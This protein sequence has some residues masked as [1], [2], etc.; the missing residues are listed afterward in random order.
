M[1]YELAPVS[2]SLAGDVARGPRTSL[3]RVVEALE[4]P[5]LRPLR[6]YH[7]Q[8]V[9]QAPCPVHD[10]ASPSLAVRWVSGGG[11]GQVL[12]RCHGCNASFEDLAAA[13]SLSPSDFFD[14]APQQS[15]ADRLGVRA[16]RSPQQ[17][18]A[19]QRRGR[20]GPLPRPIARP[21][22]VELQQ[23]EPEHT[24][25][26]VE[27]YPYTDAQGNLVQEVIRERCTSC[28]TSHKSFRQVFVVGDRRVKR[29]P[30]GF[31]AVLYR[32]PQ[33]LAGVAA[34]TTVWLLEGEKDVAAAEALGLLATTN[35]QGGRNFTP[36]LA[37][38][39]RGAD[40]RVVLDRDDTGWDRGV[41]AHRELTALG[42]TVEL[43]LPAPTTA[44][45]DFS[46]HLDAGHT[47]DQLVPVH[48]EEVAA[49]AALGLV[50]SKAAGVEQT[51]AETQ[52]QLSWPGSPAAPR[53]RRRC[54]SR[55]AGRRRPKSGTRRSTA[56]WTPSGP[57]P[58]TPG[59][60]GPRRP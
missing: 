22:S 45:S 2:E 50:R 16:G 53:G 43:L 25:V 33:V 42:A 60:C 11:R 57:T 41:A 26:T 10:D 32:L 12:L 40:V 29:K 44:K 3:R 4:A 13:L 37:E 30:E 47:L 52:A 17:R 49:W 27:T 28:P 20:L 38:A 21:V 46:D 48:V 39:L 1:S 9:F 58:R 59:R 31:T 6:G 14:E 56:P 19:G 35:A 24:W 23:V 51:L 5:H 8:D 15:H 54:A 34:G 55:A 7:G 18:R 36:E